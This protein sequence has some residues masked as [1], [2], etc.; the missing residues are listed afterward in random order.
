M[1]YSPTVAHSWLSSLLTW[2][3]ILSTNR[4]SQAGHGLRTLSIKSL[5]IEDLLR[6]PLVSTP[7]SHSSASE[8]VLAMWQLFLT[9]LHLTKL[10]RIYGAK[11]FVPLT[12]AEAGG[13]LR[14]DSSLS[15]LS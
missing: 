3:L 4:P 7:Q 13:G 12:P 1:V 5:E 2:F 11:V 6:Y 14:G 10:L 9:F 15:G 8:V